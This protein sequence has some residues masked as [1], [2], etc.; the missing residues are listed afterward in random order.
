[1]FAA[2]EQVEAPAQAAGVSAGQ[3]SG[4]ASNKPGGKAA[5]R[6]TVT[7][8]ILRVYPASALSGLPAA[9]PTRNGW[10]IIEL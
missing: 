2:W 4:E 6:S 8:L 3:T 9:V 1:V 10:L 7:R 5:S